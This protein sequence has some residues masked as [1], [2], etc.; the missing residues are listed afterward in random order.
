MD[1]VV[2]EADLS[3]PSTIRSFVYAGKIKK[4]EVAPTDHFSDN[5]FT[6]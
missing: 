1:D 5:C 3:K 6:L 2:D 4:L